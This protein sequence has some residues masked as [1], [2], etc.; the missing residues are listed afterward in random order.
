MRPTKW[1]LILV[2]LLGTCA[3]CG[4]S[5]LWRTPV[6][7][8][9]AGLV[10]MYSAPLTTNFSNTPVPAKR[11]VGAASTMYIRDIFFTGLDVAFDDASIQK[12]AKNGGLSK[13]YYA[14]Y[15][16]KS[17]LGVFGMFTTKVYGE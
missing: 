13:I 10:T 16:A 5:A 14:D 1:A 7:P 17:V 6:R 12:A 9:H 2:F 3:G 8:P 15:E 4:G 11:R